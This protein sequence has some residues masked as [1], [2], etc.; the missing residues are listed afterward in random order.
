VRLGVKAADPEG[1]RR[2]EVAVE[3]KGAAGV[4]RIPLESHPEW[5]HREETVDWEAI[6]APTEVVVLVRRDGDGEAAAG[7]VFLDVRFDRL[8]ALRKLSTSAGAR[9]GG[10][11]LASL[12]G[13]L[14]TALVG[15]ASGGW[16][17]GEASGAVEGFPGRE[18][19]AGASW[20]RRLGRDFVH[21]VGAVSIAVLA[22]VIYLAG[23][24]GH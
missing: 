7:T 21:G 8:P 1:S 3:I 23:A 16:R 13:A 12:L 10:V 5:S 22:I 4:Q 2:I 17:G 15:A 20:L 11:L 6:G 14:L 18:P 19:A 9:F 24:K